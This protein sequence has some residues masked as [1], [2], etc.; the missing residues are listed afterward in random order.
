MQGLGEGSFGQV[1]AGGGQP[2]ANEKGSD[3]DDKY[4]Y[5]LYKPQMKYRN[6]G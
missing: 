1:R 4:K 5:I 3:D 2:Q 6:V